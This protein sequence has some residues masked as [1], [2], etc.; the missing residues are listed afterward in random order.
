LNDDAATNTVYIPSELQP[1]F[2]E[3]GHQEVVV[4]SATAPPPDSASELVE[5]LQ[6]K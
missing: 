6:V 1:A 5:E 3:E 2:I 4:V